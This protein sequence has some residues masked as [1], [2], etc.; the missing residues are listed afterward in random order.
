MMTSM[1]SKVAAFGAFLSLGIAQ[2]QADVPAVVGTSL[3]AIQ[4]DALAAI[5]LVWPILMAVLG[6]FV[7]LKIVKRVVAKI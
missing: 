4:T 3:A 2:A 1:K 6:G 7:I 5:D